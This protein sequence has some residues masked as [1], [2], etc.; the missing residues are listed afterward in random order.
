MT[1]HHALATVA[2]DETTDGDKTD[3]RGTKEGSGDVLDKDGGSFT[4]DDVDDDDSDCEESDDAETVGED[5]R[6]IVPQTTLNMIN[7]GAA[8]VLSRAVKETFE[9]IKHNTQHNVTNPIVAEIVGGM[10]TSAM[11]GAVNRYIEGFTVLE[12]AVVKQEL[13]R[14]RKRERTRERKRINTRVYRA[15]K[16]AKI[17]AAQAK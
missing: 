6:F 9:S 2:M 3:A 15:K 7:E 12:N 5:T 4:D 10:F 17:A 13:S 16:K 14:E 11:R 8:I 1:I